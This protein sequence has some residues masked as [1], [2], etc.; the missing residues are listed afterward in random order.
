MA[1]QE[2]TDQRSRQPFDQLS[3]FIAARMTEK[4]GF[5]ALELAPAGACRAAWMQPS[6]PFARLQA[7]LRLRP[8][9]A[10]SSAEATG[11]TTLPHPSDKRLQALFSF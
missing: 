11:K 2:V 6:L 9:R 1:G 7:A 5:I 8:R 4:D 3:F 10:L